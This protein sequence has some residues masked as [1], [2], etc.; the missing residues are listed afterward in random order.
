LLSYGSEDRGL[1]RAARCVH[2]GRRAR[3]DPGHR[4]GSP[5]RP[6]WAGRAMRRVLPA[7]LL[8][9]S[10]LAGLAVSPLLRLG[11]PVQLA[12]AFAAVAAVALLV[13]PAARV[14]AAGVVFALAG[15]WW[16]SVRLDALDQSPLRA[17]VGRAGRAL[18]EVTSE[19]RVGRFQQRQFGRVRVFMGRPL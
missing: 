15:W 9:G 3:R 13:P 8:L 6:A 14:V 11:P 10:A 4:P 1:P 16:G 17:E 7:H 12:P 18:V 5:R 19:A 2:L